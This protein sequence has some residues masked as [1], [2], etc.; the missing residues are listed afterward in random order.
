MSSTYH[1]DMA[2]SS[3]NLLLFLQKIDMV[4][5]LSEKEL[6]EFYYQAKN[7]CYFEEEW[8]GKNFE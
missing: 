7:T 2:I 6:E 5:L 3:A 4:Y 1:D 8:F